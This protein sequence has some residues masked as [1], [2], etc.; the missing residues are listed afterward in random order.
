MYNKL[1][2]DYTNLNKQIDYIYENKRFPDNP[3]TFTQF[4]SEER[5]H[6]PSQK[7][8]IESITRIDAKVI[9]EDKKLI[10]TPVGSSLEGQ[11][12]TGYKL[13]VSGYINYN[14][15]YVSKKL[16]QSLHSFRKKKEFCKYIVLENKIDSPE[17]IRVNTYIENICMVNFNE[18]SLDI[19]LALFLDVELCP[20]CFR[21]NKKAC[22]E[23]CSSI[24]TIGLAKKLPSNPIYFKET[25]VSKKLKIPSL[26]PN[27]KYIK[28]ISSN[29]KII[30]VRAIDTK[31]KTSYE[32]QNL[33]GCKL[34]VEFKTE[35]LIVYTADNELESIHSARF[36][37]YDSAF[38]VIPCEIDGYC[39]EGL[40]EEDKICVKAYIEDICIKNI[41]GRYLNRCLTLFLDGE[42]KCI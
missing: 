18:R 21:Q 25:T 12:L 39:I 26:K 37:C 35:D 1:P 38:I 42:V 23:G 15:I 2:C 31:E 33:S 22:F 5:F 17:F 13:I 24:K 27:A 20:A 10:E 8:D 19:C 40:L 29:V 41:D 3:T 9:I 30:S 34:I 4:I 16:E 32:G 6:V 7:P 11:G 14:I 28:S 36:E